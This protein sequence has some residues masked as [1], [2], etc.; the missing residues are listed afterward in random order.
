MDTIHLHPPTINATT[1]M[2]PVAPIVVGLPAGTLHGTVCP[3]TKMSAIA[4]RTPNPMFRICEK[5][6]SPGYSEG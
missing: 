2:T 6:E 3:E 4:G 5:S 1:A